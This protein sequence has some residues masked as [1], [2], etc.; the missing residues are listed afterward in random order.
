MKYGFIIIQT[1][2][3]EKLKN[4]V[5]DYFEPKISYA[6]AF[7]SPIMDDFFVKSGG[8]NQDQYYLMGI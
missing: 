7:F 2:C 8:K 6:D 1:F 5:I 3:L 4:V